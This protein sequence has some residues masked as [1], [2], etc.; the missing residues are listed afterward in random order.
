VNK[1]I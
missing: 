1:T